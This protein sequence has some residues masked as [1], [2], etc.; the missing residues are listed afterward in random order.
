MQLKEYKQDD[1]K[2]LGCDEAGRG[3][4][5]GPVIIAGIV[6]K[7]G[8]DED[9][10]KQIKDSKKLSENK[11]NELYKYIINNSYYSVK[12]KSAKNIDEKGI[13]NCIA[14]SINEIYEELKQYSDITIFD[15]NQDPVNKLNFNTLINAD[16]YVKEVSAAS[17]VAKV[18]HDKLMYEYAKKY[19]E[20]LFEKHKGYGTAEHRNLIKEYGKCPIHRKSFKIKGYDDNPYMEKLKE[21][22]RIREQ[23]K[24]YHSK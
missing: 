8:F 5:A 20:Y 2:V 16:Q 23:L 6:F 21:E 22:A 7:D 24:K 10:K 12:I 3:P 11:R 15:G 18:I 1:R 13:W 17:I 9:I 14:L 4:L 19:P